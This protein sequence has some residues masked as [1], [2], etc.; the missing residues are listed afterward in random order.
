MPIHRRCTPAWRRVTEGSDLALC[1][2]R[3]AN[4]FELGGAR[5][6]RAQEGEAGGVRVILDHARP[7]FSCIR[8]YDMDARSTRPPIAARAPLKR[9]SHV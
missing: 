4:E 6:A 2:L 5:F 9:C 8:R 1:L 3:P 7:R